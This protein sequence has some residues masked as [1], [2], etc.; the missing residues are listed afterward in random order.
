MFVV[1]IVGDPGDRLVRRF[2]VFAR[3]APDRLALTR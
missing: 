3:G 1:V 2:R